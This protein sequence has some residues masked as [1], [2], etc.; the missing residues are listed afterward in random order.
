MR[1]S[2]LLAGLIAAGALQSTAAL[3]QAA[4]APQAPPTVTD[5]KQIGD[6]TVR[7]FSVS[8][9]SPCDMYVE[10]HADAS[11]QR[12]LSV[13]IAYVPKDD[14][15]VVDIAVPLGVRIATGVVI[16]TDSY[17]SPTLGFRRCDQAGCYVEGLM[18]NDM[19]ASLAKS[20]PNASVN[21]VAD[22]GKAFPIKLSLNGFAGAHDAMAQMAKTKAKD[23]PASEAP[24]K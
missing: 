11:Q 16:K 24:K 4:P 3:A 18:P 9:A 1:F 10:Y 22:D 13:S 15:N 6:W 20:G 8:S 23:T 7:C 2:R 21:I 5:N 14:R 12:V 17:T 19:I